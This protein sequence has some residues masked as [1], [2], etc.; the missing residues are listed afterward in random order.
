MNYPGAKAESSQPRS[1][2]LGKKQSK[3]KHFPPHI[4]TGRLHKALTGEGLTARLLLLCPRTANHLGSTS[5]EITALVSCTA[6]QE[7][8]HQDSW[9]WYAHLATFHPIPLIS[10]RTPPRSVAELI[11]QLVATKSACPPFLPPHKVVVPSLL[12]QF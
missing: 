6:P 1:S 10:A 12:H 7:K 2:L 8:L 4:G 9:E 5:R 3:T 11:S